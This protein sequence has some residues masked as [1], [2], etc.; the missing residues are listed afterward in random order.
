MTHSLPQLNYAYNA[1]EPYIDAQTM[2]IH[3][4]KHHQTYIDKLNEALEKH[5]E[6]KETSL[7]EML[8][9]LE[10]VPE[11]IRTAVRNNGGGHYNHSLFWEIMSPDAKPVS[12]K[13]KEDIEK[14]WGTVE[15]FKEEFI[16]AAATHFA[17]GWTWLS[18]DKNGELQ[19]G[20]TPN[21][22]N[23]LME[24]MT[25]I[26]VIDVWEHAYYLKYQNRRPEFIKNWLDNVACGDK[27][28]EIYLSKLNT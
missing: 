22:D 24:E 12:G 13:L 18:I 19:I 16:E 27:I 10:K 3:H 6:L 17:S 11:D 7:E 21:H 5:P 20:S 25:P 28:G 4:T 26:M 2:E 23:P 14:K 9:N 15:K 1:L 8:K